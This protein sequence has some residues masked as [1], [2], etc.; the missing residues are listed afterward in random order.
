MCK[1]VPENIDGI[2]RKWQ[3]G[4]GTLTNKLSK[5]DI[6]NYNVVGLLVT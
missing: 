2:V 3:V 1:E 5:I 6:G 4:I